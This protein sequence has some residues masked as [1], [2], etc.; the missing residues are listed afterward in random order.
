ML[1]VRSCPC[2]GPHSRCRDITHPARS[3][4]S[5]GKRQPSSSLEVLAQEL[6]LAETSGDWDWTPHRASLFPWGGSRLRQSGSSNFL[7]WVQEGRVGQR[8]VWVN[9]TQEVCWGR[10]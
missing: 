9:C 4:Q 1:S 7:G 10:M 6:P 3:G 8:S 2:R 5:P